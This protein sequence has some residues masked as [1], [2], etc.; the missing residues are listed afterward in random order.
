VSSFRA[1]TV[2]FKVVFFGYPLYFLLK[3]EAFGLLD[4][5]LMH[6]EILDQKGFVLN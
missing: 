3:I 6:V 2:R 4:N 5:I 1:G